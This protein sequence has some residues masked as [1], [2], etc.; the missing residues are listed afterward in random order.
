MCRAHIFKPFH[1]FPGIDCLWLSRRGR[2]WRLWSSFWDLLLN[3]SRPVLG[4]N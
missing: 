1:Q 2:N 3:H 4:F